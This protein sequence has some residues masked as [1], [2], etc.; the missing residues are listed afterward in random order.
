M[1]VRANDADLADN[2]VVQIMINMLACAKWQNI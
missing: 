1:L 2:G